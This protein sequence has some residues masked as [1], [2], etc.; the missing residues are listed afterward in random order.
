MDFRS[1]PLHWLITHEVDLADREVESIRAVKTEHPHGLHA[2][3][4]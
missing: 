1:I 3:S 2:V 4:G